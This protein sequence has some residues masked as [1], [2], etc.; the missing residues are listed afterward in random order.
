MAETLRVALISEVFF[1][2]TAGERLLALLQEARRQGAELAVLPEIPLNPWS[3]APTSANDDDAES[4][5][6]SAA[7]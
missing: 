7:G 5:T 6:A 3:P 2:E 1:D 4:S